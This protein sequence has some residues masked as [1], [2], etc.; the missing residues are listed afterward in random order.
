MIMI[1]M[2]MINNNI[3][4]VLQLQSAPFNNNNLTTSECP[5]LA[6]KW[7]GVHPSFYVDSILW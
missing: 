4:F 7:R 6:A 2:I 3:T 1:I 5:S